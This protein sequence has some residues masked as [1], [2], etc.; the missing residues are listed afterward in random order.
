MRIADFYLCDECK[1]ANHAELSNTL[2]VN[3]HKQ[4]EGKEQKEVTI[5]FEKLCDKHKKE[6]EE[7]FKK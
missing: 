7:L 3:F 1:I 2:Y 6:L 4:V 5:K